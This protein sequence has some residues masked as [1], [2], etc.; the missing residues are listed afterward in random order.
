MPVAPRLTDD[1]CAG[2]RVGITMYGNAISQCEENI[3]AN[4]EELLAKNLEVV[5]AREAYRAA[6]AA[7]ADFMTLMNMMMNIAQLESQRVMLSTERMMLL[8][9]K[10]MLQQMQDSLLQQL[11][12]GGCIGR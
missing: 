5:N 4:S 1:Q 3:L 8:A 2:I 9:Q 12:A 6:A 7:G 11:I 10:P